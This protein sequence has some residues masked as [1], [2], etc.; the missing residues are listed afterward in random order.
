M[1]A[2]QL[3]LDMCISLSSWGNDNGPYWTVLRIARAGEVEGAVEDCLGAGKV[4]GSLNPPLACTVTSWV[5]KGS[6]GRGTKER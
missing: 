3:F 1:L 4:G 6:G 2:S 5:E